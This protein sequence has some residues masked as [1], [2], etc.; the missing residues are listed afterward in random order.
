MYTLEELEVY[1]LTTEIRR[2]IS[3]LSKKLPKDEMYLLKNQMLRASR[4]APANIAEGYGR[5]HYQEQIQYCRQARGSLFE[6]KDHLMVC[7]EENYINKD[8]CVERAEAIEIT[9][10]KLNGYI[11]YLNNQKSKK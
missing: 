11:K 2:N 8:E 4:S 1:K 10:K 7:L 3:T 6:L 5:Y 9:V